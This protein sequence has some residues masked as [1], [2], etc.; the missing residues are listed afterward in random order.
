MFEVPLDAWYVWIG[1]AVVSST[2]LGVVGLLPSAPPPDA[3]GSARTVDSVAASDHAA[4]GRHPLSNAEAVRLGADSISLRGAGG[5]A[6]AAFGYGPV[7]PVVG[8]P[9]LDAV[10]R[11]KPPTRVFETFDAFERRAAR[12]RRDAPQWRGASELV[13]RRVNSGGSDVVLAG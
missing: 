5:T 3:S 12:A 8:D 10:L 2:T 4:V 7:T 6:H 11:G 9:K 13:V 1:L